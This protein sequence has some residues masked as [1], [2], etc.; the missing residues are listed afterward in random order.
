MCFTSWKAR[1]WR[2]FLD[3]DSDL[4]WA[5]EALQL[6]HFIARHRHTCQNHSVNTDVYNTDDIWITPNIIEH[7]PSFS[8]CSLGGL[9]HSGQLRLSGGQ[10]YCVWGCGPLQRGLQDQFDAH[11]PNAGHLLCQH[12]TGCAWRL[13]SCH[14]HL[15]HDWQQPWQPWE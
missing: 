8:Q 2:A 10:E 15:S 14:H 1:K 3:V 5:F 11:F 12:H 13:G 7:H 9:H 6:R 4:Q